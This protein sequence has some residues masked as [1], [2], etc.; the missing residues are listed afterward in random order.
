MDE[1]KG[2]EKKGAIKEE[3]QEN[4]K[5]RYT[6]TNN[7]TNDKADHDKVRYN[8]V[9]QGIKIEL[10]NEQKIEKE[11]ENC[12]GNIGRLNREGL[13]KEKQIKKK[14][15]RRKGPS[16]FVKIFGIAALVTIVL[17][18]MIALAGVTVYKTFIYDEGSKG[19][20]SEEQAKGDN[21]TGTE[22]D[23]LPDESLNK[24]VAVFGTDATGRLTDVIFVVNLDR[25][26]KEVNVIA[27]PRDT[28]V[29]WT[30][31]QINVVPTR[32]RWVRSSKI[33]EMTSLGGIENIR[34][35]TI[36]TIEQLLGVKVDEYVI[37]NLNAFREIVDAIGGVEIEVKQR[38]KKDD[39]SQNLHIDL[40]PGIQI[41]DGDKAEQ[42]VRFRDYR[43]GDIGRIEAQQEFLQALA[44]KV[45]SLETI[46]K[47][48]QIAK[49]VYDSVETDI[50][51]EEI[52][53]YIPYVK[54]IKPQNLNFYML[55]GDAHLEGGISYYFLDQEEVIKLVEEVFF[56]TNK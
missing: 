8:E 47:L 52:L 41:L 50:K 30:K 15:G 53:K 2:K 10:E 12:Q 19:I 36:Q 26:S 9:N 51:K 31:E 49:I 14:K 17:I 13:N 48:P 3:E 11:V 22:I 1:Y 44:K 42:F 33:N 43:T 28:K 54:N 5:E 37:V 55:P 35:L 56:K 16:P 46:G 40:Q 24:T 34:S 4:R 39:F 38:M 29:E 45:L 27:V 21:N 7:E 18:G 25:D 20:I 23:L 6:N 32:H